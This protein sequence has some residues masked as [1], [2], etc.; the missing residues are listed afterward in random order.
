[1]IAIILI[2][3]SILEF[4]K[5]FD[6]SYKVDESKNYQESQFIVVQQTKNCTRKSNATE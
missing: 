2:I 3:L 1:M 6:G 5:G 4:K